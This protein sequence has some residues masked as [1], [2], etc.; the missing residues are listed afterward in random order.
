MIVGG[1]S[2]HYDVGLSASS[3]IKTTH[4]IVKKVITQFPVNLTEGQEIAVYFLPIKTEKL[5]HKNG[6]CYYSDREEAL[7]IIGNKLVA[8]EAYTPREWNET[9]TA[10]AIGRISIGTCCGTIWYNHDYKDVLKKV[11][12]LRKD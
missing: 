8:P 9:E 3:L 12:A 7:P 5:K 1:I 4:Y 2:P 10:I 6:A 11:G